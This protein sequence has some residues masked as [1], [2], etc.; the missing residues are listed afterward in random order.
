MPAASSSDRNC[1]ASRPTSVAFS[2]SRMIGVCFSASSNSLRRSICLMSITPLRKK[3]TA[4]ARDERWILNANCAPARRYVRQ[5]EG[6]YS[7]CWFHSSDDFPFVNFSR[8]VARRMLA[9][10]WLADCGLVPQCQNVWC[11]ALNLK[12]RPVDLCR[13]FEPRSVSLKW[14]APSKPAF[15]GESAIYPTLLK[16]ADSSSHPPM[17]PMAAI[18]SNSAASCKCLSILSPISSMILPGSSLGA[19]LESEYGFYYRTVGQKAI[20]S[21]SINE[22]LSWT[23]RTPST[24]Q[25]ATRLSVAIRLH[26]GHPFIKANRQTIPDHPLEDQCWCFSS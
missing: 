5:C 6:Q 1:T 11:F 17:N 3:T 2:R 24:Q 9:E 19:F 26:C 8:R 23:S 13:W 4:S 16:A 10:I 20:V 14:P 25:N 21:P 7:T 22:R 15:D 12:R 18:P